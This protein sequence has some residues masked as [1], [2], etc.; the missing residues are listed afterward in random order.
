MESEQPAAGQNRVLIPTPGVGA[1]IGLI[2][3]S[4]G[5]RKSAAAAAGV[6]IA[7][8]QR[9]IN[10]EVAAPFDCIARLAHAAGFSLDWI[11]TGT[12]PQMKGKMSTSE[13][14][15]SYGLVPLY[16][17]RVS[18]GHGT[19]SEGAQVLA[20]LAFTRYW[21]RK[22]GVSEG[23]L[24]AVRVDGDSMEPTLR[25]GDMVLVDHQ[26]REVAGDDIYVIRLEDH[27]YAKRL[28]RVFG[29][30]LEVISDNPVYSP[31]TIAADRVHE[32]DIIGRVIYRGGL[33]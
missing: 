21:L 23:Q 16:D 18:A 19:W 5:N 31:M 14:G 32:L 8:L 2:A 27:L 26:R 9:Y 25:E 6:S 10:D 11:A 28:R 33:I 7:S 12:G 1:R 17:A 13:P 4:I 29:G 20:R 30:G 3:E 15:E 22:L 24:S